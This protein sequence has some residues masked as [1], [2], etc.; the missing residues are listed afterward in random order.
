MQKANLAYEKT[1]PRAAAQS[2]SAAQS[3]AASHDKYIASLSSLS[4]T[5]A[6]VKKGHAESVGEHRQ[7]ATREVARIMCGVADASWRSRVEATRRGGEKA[8]E[9]VARGVWCESGMPGLAPEEDEPAVAAPAQQ[10]P[11]QQQAASTRGPRPLYTTTDSAFS[12]SSQYQQPDPALFRP[13]PGL[14]ANTYL[15]QLSAQGAPQ[16]LQ[17]PPPA[18]QTPSSQP[19]SPRPAPRSPSRNSTFFNDERAPSSQNDSDSVRT[20]TGTGRDSGSTRHTTASASPFSSEDGS[21]QQQRE[22]DRIIAPKGFVLED[23]DPLSPEFECRDRNRYEE[24]S[25]SPPAQPQGISWARD[26]RP[27]E[28]TESSASERN[29][30]ARMREKYAEEKERHGGAA[31]G[32][33]GS[34]RGDESAG[35]G[36]ASTRSRADEQSERSD[37]STSASLHSKE[38]TWCFHAGPAPGS[39]HLARIEPRPAVQ[40]HAPV[41]LGLFLG[42]PTHSPLLALDAA[43]HIEPADRHL[44]LDGLVEHLRA[45][46]RRVWPR[47]V[48]A[49]WQLAT[50]RAPVVHGARSALLT[51][52]PP[53][54]GERRAGSVL[55]QPDA[56]EPRRG[57]GALERLRVRAV[58]G[59]QVRQ[60]RWECDRFAEECWRWEALLRAGVSRQAVRSDETGGEGACA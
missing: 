21:Q 38:L 52:E 31:S 39:V 55:V 48:V 34:Q 36:S 56:D 8:G 4:S 58:L 10:Q 9:V 30:V 14:P 35:W 15:V 43:R 12:S 59:E 13:A 27:L 7:R 23:S 33:N 17:A 29:F 20:A 50:T 37:V 22:R 18:T 47:D 57:R 53:A 19:P 60:E 24:K 49:V 16:T 28:R 11:S 1:R 6:S 25:I 42:A 32:T 26:D 3:A 44:D 40:Q 41:E 2:P 54:A 45:R 51:P 46:V 5:I